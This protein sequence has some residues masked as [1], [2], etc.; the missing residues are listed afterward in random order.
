MSDTALVAPHIF[1]RALQTGAVVVAGL[2]LTRTHEVVSPLI[3]GPIAAQQLTD[4]NSEYIATQLASTWLNNSNLILYAM[5]VTIFVIW[6]TPAVAYFR[7]LTSTTG[8][9]K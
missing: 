5:V 8:T 7:K 6:Y 2:T 9:P 4:G 1:K 3:S